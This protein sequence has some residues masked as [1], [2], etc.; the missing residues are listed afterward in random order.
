MAASFSWP[1]GKR[2]AL[3]LSFDDARLTQVDAGIPILDHF[4]VRATFYVSFAALEKRLDAWKAALARGHEAG[5]H[6]LSHPCTGNF[7][8]S[9]QQAL[10]D[11]TLERMAGELDGASARI[12]E[13]LA[14]T[15]RTFAYPCGQTFVGR[16]EKLQSYIPLVAKRFLAGRGF[17]SESDNDPLFCDLAQVSGKSM[18]CD[19]FEELA[20]A[21]ETARLAGAW[22]VLVGHDV[23]P[24]GRQ[25]VRPATLEALCRLA[26]D[27]GKGIWLDTVAN[28]ADYVKARRPA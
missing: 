8:W 11:F 22:M 26:T 25:G 6:T 28:V 2:M 12:R 15:P 14:V 7:H 1:D 18:D 9:R 16:G 21:I 20:P 10:E 19:T 5:N 24:E 17:L 4:G 13:L 3:S 23:R 27:P